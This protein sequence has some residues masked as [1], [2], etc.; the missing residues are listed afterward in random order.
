MKQ[1]PR[2]NHDD[3]AWG[4]VSSLLTCWRVTVKKTKMILSQLDAEMIQLK[5]SY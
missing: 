2:F 5:L 4:N 1:I 3:R